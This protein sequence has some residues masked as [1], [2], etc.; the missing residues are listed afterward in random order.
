MRFLANITKTKAH[1]DRVID[2]YLLRASNKMR[3]LRGKQKGQAD[4]EQLVQTFADYGHYMSPDLLN[5][6][7]S[8]TPEQRG[9]FLSAAAETFEAA[10][11]TGF[12]TSPMY[13]SFPEHEDVMLDFELVSFLLEFGYQDAYHFSGEEYGANPITGEQ[14]DDL[15]ADPDKDVKFCKPLLRGRSVYQPVYLGFDED[16]SKLAQD[17]LR[18]LSPLT[19]DQA[20][21]ISACVDEGFVTSEDLSRVKFREKLPALV[22]LVA[23]EVYDAAA[24]SV[25]DALRLAA[26]FSGGD[27]SLSTPVK[28]ALPKAAAKRVL[29]LAES[30]VNQ[31]K[32]GGVE[33]ILRHEETWK[34]LIRHV[35]TPRA[36]KVAPLLSMSV[37]DARSGKIRSWNYGFAIASPAEAAE[38]ASKRPGTFVRSAVWLSRRF[39]EAGADRGPLLE[40]ASVA[41]DAAPVPALLQLHKH[42]TRTIQKKDRFHIM[43]NGRMLHSEHAKEKYDDLVQ[44]L[45]GSLTRRLGGLLP[46]GSVENGENRFLPVGGRTASVSSN[47]SV[48]GDSVEIRDKHASV[49][50]LFLHWKD[51][52]DVDLSAVFF[53]DKGD[54]VDNCSYY[55]L[56][57]RGKGNHSLA[58]H[59]GDIRDGSRGAAEYVD[60]D[61]GRA[62]EAGIRYAMLTANVYSGKPFAEFPTLV[63]VMA[64][65][66][67]TGKHFEAEKVETSMR[68]TSSSTACTC[69]MLDLDTMRLIYIDQPDNWAQLSNVRSREGELQNQFKMLSEYGDYRASLAD[70]IRFAGT[71]GGPV[72]TDKEAVEKR[73][74]I[75]ATL[76][77]VGGP[78]AEQ[79]HELDTSPW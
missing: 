78:D 23:P 38:M 4:I 41:F 30:L 32:D 44:V 55:Q 47:G 13:R 50:R 6:M 45:E 51:A 1:H 20:E 33:D 17:I 77:G 64:R 65:D 60:V 48:R 54:Q 70:V 66:G 14:T 56:S 5:T 73:T 75:L 46:W 57:T 10:F 52:S 15:K 3:V 24:I 21:F 62:K 69:A 31:A 42:L 40:A 28:F 9:S 22:G 49:M 25:T 11:G 18:S 59:S 72:L 68:V 7:R 58:V 67:R 37:A 8:L 53:N 2:S 34:R 61:V 39:D 16:V 76:A 71:E 43:K 27:V 26:H 63:G 79:Q 35:G 36:E 29:R 12:K 74:E 19:P